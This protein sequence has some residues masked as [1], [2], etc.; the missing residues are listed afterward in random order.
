MRLV[1]LDNI[2]CTGRS[3]IEKALKDKELSEI[4]FPCSEWDCVIV[5]DGERYKIIVRKKS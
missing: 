1:D 5:N 3:L 2:T 4:T